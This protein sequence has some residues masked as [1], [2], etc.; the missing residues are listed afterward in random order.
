MV[1]IE[2]DEAQG[3]APTALRRDLGVCEDGTC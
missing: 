2:Y 1:V 3:I